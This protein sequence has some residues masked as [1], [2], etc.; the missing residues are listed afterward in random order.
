VKLSEFSNP[1]DSTGCCVA[2]YDPDP[3]RFVSA[4]LDVSSKPFDFAGLSD[5]DKLSEETNSPEFQP[6]VAIGAFQKTKADGSKIVVPSII[7]ELPF[8]FDAANR[9]DSV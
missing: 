7:L 2:A 5:A 3:A 9:N 1:F 8:E 6:F 4:N